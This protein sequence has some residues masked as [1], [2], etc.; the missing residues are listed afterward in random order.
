LRNYEI[1]RQ[2]KS[3]HYPDELTFDQFDMLKWES[4]KQ[5]GLDDDRDLHKIAEEVASYA[6]VTGAQIY[7]QVDGETDTMYSKGMRICNR[8]GMWEVVTMKGLKI[9]NA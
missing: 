6:Q 7:T 1:F 3:G 4:A 9:N 8:T 2:I 5:F